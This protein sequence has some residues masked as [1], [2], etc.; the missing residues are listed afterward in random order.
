MNK[1]IYFIL[2][3]YILSFSFFI[4]NAQVDPPRY[5]ID[6]IQV[7]G[8][9]SHSLT[10]EAFYLE[11]RGYLNPPENYMS[12]LFN[13]PGDLMWVQCKGGYYIESAN[14]P[15][16]NKFN[17]D[18][19]N[20][21]GVYIEYKLKNSITVVCTNT[22]TDVASATELSNQQKTINNQTVETVMSNRMIWVYII[23]IF[24]ILFVIFS[25]SKNRK[26]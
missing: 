7:G 21:V 25:K 4:V 16:D 19:F 18:K 2:S 9:G 3:I 20:G 11:E 15:T 26:L 22:P 1:K 17:I 5:G 6:V 13:S 14:S 12:I 24:I 23:I 8:I 10:K